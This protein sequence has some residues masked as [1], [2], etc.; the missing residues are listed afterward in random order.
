MFNLFSWTPLT[1]PPPPLHPPPPPPNLGS[2]SP[3]WCAVREKLRNPSAYFQKGELN[4]SAQC[5][6]EFLNK[7]CFISLFE[8]YCM[9]PPE[10][11]MSCLQPTVLWITRFYNNANYYTYIWCRTYFSGNTTVSSKG[12]RGPTISTTLLFGS[13][14]SFSSHCWSKHCSNS[15]FKLLSVPS[16][17]ALG[18]SFHLLPLYHTNPTGCLSQCNERQSSHWAPGSGQ[19]HN[20]T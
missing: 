18:C 3:L 15:S 13:L 10:A 2:A 1:P 9:C 20:R 8:T 6:C 14:S 12:Q 11:I 7:T 4:L 16:D 5:K 17:A 19:Q